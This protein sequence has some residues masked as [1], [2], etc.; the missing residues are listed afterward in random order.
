MT[1][2][3]CGGGGG[4]DDDDGDGG[5][6]A[7]EDEGFRRAAWGGAKSIA[8]N[9]ASKADRYGNKGGAKPGMGEKGDMEVTFHAGLEE[10]GA[11]MKKKKERGG[12]KKTETVWEK[13]VREREEKAAAKKLAKKLAKRPAK[14]PAKEPAK[15]LRRSL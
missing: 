12:L 15:E 1:Y 4:D 11:R 5:G 10:F 8:S 3:S 14:R 9:N 2:V 6:D 7:S 13:Q